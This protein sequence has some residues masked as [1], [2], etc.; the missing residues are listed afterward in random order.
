MSVKVCSR[1]CPNEQSRRKHG[2]K[3]LQR[4]FQ[5]DWLFDAGVDGIITNKPSLL[6][7]RIS[8]KYNRISGRLR[9]SFKWT[10]LSSLKCVFF[11]KNKIFR[12]D[13][14]FF[15]CFSFLCWSEPS[16]EKSNFLHKI[17]FRI[18][19]DLFLSKLNV[20]YQ[21]WPL[22]NLLSVLSKNITIFTTIY[23]EKCPSSIPC[24]DSNPWPLE[25]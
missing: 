20:F 12:S 4:W 21:T 8:L 1:I 16:V 2:E 19:Y 22:F 15:S 11:K 5:M 17:W 24:W 14:I 10:R 18:Y 6:S 25:C 9:S 3:V 7:E 23:Y 13:P